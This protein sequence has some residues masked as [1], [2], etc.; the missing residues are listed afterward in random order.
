MIWTSDASAKVP[1]RF[2][3]RLNHGLGPDS[4]II[5]LSQKGFTLSEQIGDEDEGLIFIFEGQSN[6]AKNIPIDKL[7][8]NFLFGQLTDISLSMPA[9]YEEASYIQRIQSVR[10]IIEKTYFIDSTWAPTGD[11]LS[12][13]LERVSQIYRGSRAEITLSTLL[14][15]E[16]GYILNIIFTDFRFKESLFKRKQL[17]R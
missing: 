12:P 13:R 3:Y 6:L 7:Q 16:G 17:W 11:K 1:I 9:L 4:V 5:S 15:S 10:G 14:N 2:P 8:T